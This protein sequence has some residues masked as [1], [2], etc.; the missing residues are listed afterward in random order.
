MRLEKQ[1]EQHYRDKNNQ[2]RGVTKRNSREKA[3]ERWSKLNQG[4][5]YFAGDWLS[6]CK[7]F[8]TN[9][10]SVYKKQTPKLISI[11]PV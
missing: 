9:Y 3:R 7:V 2:K 11:L 10:I 5:L 6:E 1:L 4:W 8:L